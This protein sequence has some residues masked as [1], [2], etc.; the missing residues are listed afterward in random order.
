MARNHIIGGKDFKTGINFNINGITI[1]TLKPDGTFKYA[2]HVKP[3]IAAK[4]V[5]R[6]I[7]KEIYNIIQED[8]D[9]VR[10]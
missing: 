6:L 4:R 10:I 1:L 5:A 7:A 2:K 8:H 3:D 9:N